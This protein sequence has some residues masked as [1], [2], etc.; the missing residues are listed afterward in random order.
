MAQRAITAGGAPEG[1]DARLIL[2]EAASSDAPVVHVARDDKRMEATRAALAFFAPDMPVISFP[3]WDCLPYDRVS[4]NADIA[5]ARMATLAALVHQM[6]GQFVLLTTLNAATQRVPA[7]QVLKDAA[8]V[9]EVD[10]RIDEE[11]LRGYLTRMGFT[12]SPT[13]MEP[14]DFAV[15]GGIIDIYPPGQS[16][17]VRLDL[18]GDVLDGARRFDPATQR[19]TEKLSVVELAPVSEVILDEAAVTRFRQNYRIEFGA[20]GTDD[21]LYE[22]VSAG[23]KY[24]GIEHWLP[25]FHERLE[26]L[27][28]YLPQATVTLDDQVTPARLARWDSI[29]DQYETRKIAMAQKGRMDTVYKPVPPGLL[30]LDDDAW[31]AAIGDHRVIQFHPLPQ[32]S[33]PGVID[34]GGR[35]GRNFS[36]ERQLESVSLF[37]SLAD[38]IKARMQVGPVVVASYSEGARERLTGLIEDEGLA[39][40]I[41][42][43][44]GTRIGK[45]GL[46]L[47]VWALEHGFETDDL[48]VISEQDVLGDRLI[49]APKKRRKA[50]NF[51]TETQSLSPGDLVV[52]VDHGIGRYKG[53]EVVTAAG[54]AHECI[55]LEYAEH[56]KLYLPV[57]NIELLSKY[58]HDEGLLDRLGGGAW[59]AKKAKLKE[60]IREMADRLIRV[61]AERALRKAPMMDPPPH[62]WEEFSARF[63]YQETDDQLRAISEVMEDL[64]S[65]SPMDRLICGDVGFG[66]TEVAMRAA[67]IAAMSGVQVAIVAPTTLLARQHAAAFAQ[68]FRGF[69]LEV[70]QLSRFVTAKEAAKTRE[71][72]AKGTID[73]VVGTHALLA[74]SVRFQNLG[75]LIIDEEQHF[76]VAHK[77][78]L[79]QM[80]SDIH[81]LTLT[82]TP[83]PRTLQLSLT[84][85]RDL[86]II[87]TPPVDRL[88][89]R[90]YVSEFDA[91]TIREALLR[92]HYR[93]GQSFY[94]VPRITDLPDVEAFL[95]EQL[96][97][98]SYVVAHGQL[99]AGDLDDRM[100][101]FYDG[102]FDVLLATTIVESGLDIPTA[103]TMV[104][105][106]ADMFGL[107][108]L[109][110]I[111]GRVGRS[112]TRA[113]AYLTTKPRVRLT[114]GAEKRLRVLGSLDTLGA[115]FSL[116]SQDLDIRG[117]GNLL[118]EEQSGQMRDVG[119]E[120]YQS[121]LEEAIA[122]IKSGELEGLSG[123]DDQ[124]APQINLGVPVLIPENYVPDLDVRLG[125]YRRLSDL[126]TKV[127][128]EGFAAELIDRFGALPKEVN[129]LMLVV[130][131]KAMCK[132][133]GIAKLDGGPK[134]ATIQ[135]HNDKFASPQ[136]LVEFIQAQDGLAKVKD[137]KIVVRRDWKKDSDKIK[138][139]FAIAR[140]LAEKVVAE[141]KKAKA[142]A[143]S[144]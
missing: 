115:G 110:Q 26:T 62:A 94:V 30:Y 69:P 138:G 141:K 81:V 11:A 47:A 42:I 112:K 61:A 37:K 143:K 55:L 95:Q 5:A 36:P 71:G 104:V 54:A 119:Y 116:A 58:G 111:R 31:E 65:G 28:D 41:A 108:Q 45:S 9:A 130:R 101:A 124:W 118:G 39:E 44:D 76:G 73:I 103:N 63:P 117:A 90:T 72:M 109:Y 102:K 70:R 14:G 68:R 79:K 27:F 105:H 51:L 10:R 15:R 12:K 126:S 125:L 46:H 128:L 127:E 24:Q 85:V 43:N 16:G 19:T 56:S 123:S 8:F 50:E 74:K 57:E 136:G 82:A 7:R 3:G 66:K 83:I 98:L 135:F 134:G 13:V 53:L 120:L 23:R 77:E 132:R 20:A 96:P 25:F 139:A 49:R 32:A 1:F 78:R 29:V 48:T 89:I 106:R 60:R 93:G 64:Q 22:A 75:L 67:F 34:A 86:S 99:A 129:T 84:G 140:D 91:V 6:P 92:E 35:I 142:K 59:Q 107:A 4:P 122:K 80:R 38:H 88:A 40:V 33:G 113:Y 114:P 17:P 97:E 121:M 131:I 144:G 21:P 87:G 137:N 133:A 52:H 18:F 100:N 2:K